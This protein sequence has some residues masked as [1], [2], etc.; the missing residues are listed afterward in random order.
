MSLLKDDIYLCVESLV[1]GKEKDCKS[2]KEGGVASR[3]YKGE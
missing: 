2:Q 1:R 3:G